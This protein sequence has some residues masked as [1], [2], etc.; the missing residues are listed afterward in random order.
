LDEDKPGRSRRPIEPVRWLQTTISGTAARLYGVGAQLDKRHLSDKGSASRS[1]PQRRAAPWL[2][3]V[4]RLANEGL[5]CG[6]F[7]LGESAE[8]WSQ[9]MPPVSARQELKPA[10][11][12]ALA[13]LRDGRE[14]E[15]TRGRYQ[16]L[17][18][19]SRSQAAYDLAELV[20][21]GVLERI[22]RGRS[23][24][25]VLTKHPNLTR[26]HWT[27]ERIRAELSSF[28]NGRQTWPSAR[29]FKAAGHA[30]LYVAASRYGGV[31]FWAA[32]LGLAR[33]ARRDRKRVV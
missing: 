9:G 31:A 2:P 16:Q 19:V 7:G 10:Q 28:C 32:E 8:E 12:R 27:S 30:D 17:A 6:I 15:L 4:L 11:H 5:E 21:A 24:R 33:G 26:R 3:S 20:E 22:G 23:T 13:V 29:E 18:E 25:Y 14:A 1:R